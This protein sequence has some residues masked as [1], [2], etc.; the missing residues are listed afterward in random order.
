[1]EAMKITRLMVFMAETRCEEDEKHE[2]KCWGHFHVTPCH[3]CEASN[4]YVVLAAHYI[5]SFFDKAAAQL[6]ALLR[7]RC[8]RP[9]LTDRRLS[10]STGTT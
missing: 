9:L 10:S 8:R 4:A 3:A 7:A 6:D 5:M 2:R 1:M